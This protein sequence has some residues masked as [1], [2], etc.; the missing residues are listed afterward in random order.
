MGGPRRTATTAFARAL[1]RSVANG[2]LLQARSSPE[3]PGSRPSRWPHTFHTSRWDYDYTGGDT[4]RG[5]LEALADKK[6]SA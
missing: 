5:S 3:S 4:N 6:S 2:T 1:R